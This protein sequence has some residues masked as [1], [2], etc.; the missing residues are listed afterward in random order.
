MADY[1]DWRDLLDDEPGAELPSAEPDGKPGQGT[2]AEP[3][4]SS[5]PTV[6]P[7]ELQALLAEK[8]RL[9]DELRAL[10]GQGPKRPEDARQARCFPVKVHTKESRIEDRRLSRH[11]EQL[12]MIAKRASER[13]A[14]WRREEDKRQLARQF[15]AADRR[16]QRVLRRL[17]E[18][19]AAEALLR[20]ATEAAI[21][22][23]WAE[24]RRHAAADHAAEM[25]RAAAW[26]ELRQQSLSEAARNRVLLRHSEQEAQTIRAE[27]LREGRAAAAQKLVLERRREARELEQ[28]LNERSRR[29]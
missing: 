28:R 15:Q 14:L 12:R 13:A 1:L 16:R 4:M 29:E 22:E 27:K 9:E 7:P 18:L 6:L 20:A 8:A 19:A 21:K 26:S 2:A 5:E 25:R 11:D 10:S 3:L 17:A 23:R 24:Q